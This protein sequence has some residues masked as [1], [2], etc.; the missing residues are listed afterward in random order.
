MHMPDL[1]LLRSFVSVVDAGSFTRAGERVH[2]TQ[3][4]V[5][6]QIQ[7]LEEQLGRPLLH[8]NSRQV[9]P[10][11]D[12]ER[13]LPYARRLLALADETHDVMAQAE[14]QDILRLG[15]PEDFAA[16]RL[17]QLLSQFFRAHPKLRYDVRCELSVNLQR[18]I[19]RGE[20]DLAVLKRD[21]DDGGAVATWPENLHWVTSQR[22]PIGWQSDPM[23]LAVFPQG[24][25]YRNRAIHA[26]ESRGRAWR[27]SYTC[28]NFAG[29][30]AAVSAGLGVSILPESG[31][32]ADHRILTRKNGFPA[33]PDT[34]LALVVARDTSR[35]TRHLAELLMSFCA[36]WA[37]APPKRRPRSGRR[38]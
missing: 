18:D 25:Q 35:A 6:Q 28:P 19:E 15:I 11:D 1:Q 29:I 4:T 37:A 13:L 14:G 33:I 16:N 7:R 21:T 24:C 17:S 27:I 8:R 10:T 20:L 23:P 5:S 26:L 22:Y 38:S 34:E 36:E 32:L 12:G 3:S 31:L 2:R 30:Q 9:T